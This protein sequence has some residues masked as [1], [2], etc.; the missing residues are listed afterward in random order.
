MALQDLVINRTWLDRSVTDEINWDAIRVPTLEFVLATNNNLKQAGLDVF[1]TT[2][3]FMNEGKATRSTALIDTAD[4]IL[5]DDDPV[6][7]TGDWT[8]TTIP[9]LGTVTTADIN[10]GT[11]DGTVIGA[12]TPAAATFTT[13]TI[14]AADVNSGTIDGT[15]IGGVAPADGTFTTLV[16][17]SVTEYL[18]VPAAAF[19]T[20]FGTTSEDR[21]SEDGILRNVD[22]GFSTRVF[23]APINLP[24]GAVVTNVRV[25]FDNNDAAV[26]MYMN[27][28]R[29]DSVG[30][31]SA[32][33]LASTPADGAGPYLDD[34]TISNATINNQSYS[35]FMEVTIDV[36]DNTNDNIFYMAVITYTVAR[37]YT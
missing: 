9:D 23:L 26:S 24:H 11:I 1:G 17:D 12:G 27:C 8:F 22:A 29:L 31:E 6:A 5:I 3:E 35:Y 7:I 32:L 37:S 30:G 25:Y 36:N 10:G 18:A 16:A 21:T 34:N 4:V 28:K 13:L 33:S 15:A 19:I 20:E 14:S 2:Y